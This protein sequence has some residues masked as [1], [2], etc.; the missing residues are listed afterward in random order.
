MSEKNQSSNIVISASVAGSVFPT[1][2][3]DIVFPVL[4]D[5]TK[6]DVHVEG[7]LYGRSVELRGS[8][9][10]DGPV[11][12]R[13]DTKINPMGMRITLKSG[14]TING[15][16]NVSPHSASKDK[17][18]RNG[19]ANTSF[20]VKGDIAVNQNIS[21]KNSIVFGSIRA[22]NCTLENSIVLGTCIVEESLKVSASTIGGYV[23]R[24][25]VF[26]GP[27]TLLHA[28]GE[29]ISKPVFAPYEDTDRVI[30]AAS[31]CYYPALRGSG[32][33]LNGVVDAG[34]AEMSRLFLE[35]DWVK[36]LATLNVALEGGESTSREKWI[37]SLGGRIGDVAKISGAIKGIATM[38]K[39][40]FEYE[41]Y[42]PNKAHEY[43]SAVS[44][45]LTEEEV[46]I[47]RAVC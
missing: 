22:V 41:H 26:S 2:E 10:I 23:S 9:L 6:N 32:S 29:S 33:M 8:V 34:R 14:I 27:C 39:C 3:K 5:G 20:L 28:L 19:L 47:L 17:T 4:V 21:L 24:D 37:L 44:E 1:S 18:I 45:N 15:S 16:L 36:A 35:T 7:A 25:I 30:S 46:W 11:V 31:V 38:L 42:H 40:G 12:A 13:G 43:L